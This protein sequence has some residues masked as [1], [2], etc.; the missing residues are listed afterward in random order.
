M[1]KPGT[2]LIVPNHILR[3]Q[4]SY[5]LSY[6]A[7][8]SNVGNSVLFVIKSEQLSFGTFGETWNATLLFNGTLL[9]VKKVSYRL[10]DISWEVV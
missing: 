10:W 9:D 1:W 2:L 8:V 6:Q 3:M 4:L 5:Q 7:N